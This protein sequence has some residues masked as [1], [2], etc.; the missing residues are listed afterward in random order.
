MLKE[1]YH[2][3]EILDPKQMVEARDKICRETMDRLVAKDTK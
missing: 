1:G 3:Q 2:I